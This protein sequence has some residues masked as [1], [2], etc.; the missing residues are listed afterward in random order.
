MALL[1]LSRRPGEGSNENDRLFQSGVLL[2]SKILLPKPSRQ[3]RILFRPM[4]PLEQVLLAYA[5]PCTRVHER[6]DAEHGKFGY[7]VFRHS[8]LNSN[9][10][11]S[12]ML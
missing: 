3:I 6:N 1:Q 10:G 4:R 8:V 2:F 5:L 7:F 12:R 11:G 9:S